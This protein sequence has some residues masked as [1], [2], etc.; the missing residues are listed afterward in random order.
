MSIRTW[1]R[2]YIGLN[3]AR[4]V[5]RDSPARSPVRSASSRNGSAPAPDQAIVIT[6]EF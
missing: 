1:P 6:D 5:A 3:C 2:S 4:R